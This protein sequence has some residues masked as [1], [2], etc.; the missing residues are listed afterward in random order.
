MRVVIAEDEV[1]LR[2]GISRILTDEGHEIVATAGDADDLLGKT[3]AHRPDLVLTDI[4]MPP[5]FA[6][7]GLR[8]AKRIRQE[9]PGTAVIVLSQYV[10]ATGAMEL[11]AD[12][13]AGIGYLLKRRILNLEDFLDSVQ[14][15]ADGG[16]S[17]D[18]D[19]ITSM[20]RREVRDH[21]D[22]GI[23]QLTP[24]RLEVL[25]LMAQGYSNAR[26]AR[27]LFVTEKAV[28]RSIALIFTTLDLPP[29]PDDHRRVLA[30]MRFLDR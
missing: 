17:I 11:L 15:V 8:A 25:Q 28:A 29:D 6:D 5:D 16:S 19:V 13:A 12:G 18:S 21:R 1:L 3:R 4:R 20:V 10:D 27:E 30:V 2:E 22:G 24:R 9:L 23:A 14:R 7:D 26:I